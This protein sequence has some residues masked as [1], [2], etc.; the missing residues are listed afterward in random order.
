MTFEK[1]QGAYELGRTMTLAAIS[2]RQLGKTFPV[3]AGF[4]MFGRNRAAKPA[5]QC[6]DLDVAIG[7][8][9][10]LLGP[11]G[12][13]KTTL[14]EILATLLLPSEGEARI[15]GH[16]V[17]KNADN[18]RGMVGYCPSATESFYP[19]LTA[20]ENLEF[21]ALINDLAS[22]EAK[23]RIGALIPLVGL[24]DSAAA[25][26]QKLSQGMKQRLAIARALLT[27]PPVLLL[28]EPSKSLDPLLQ[29][30][31]WRL[32]RGVIAEKMGKTILLVT[33]SLAEVN[34]ICDRMAILKQGRIV[35]EGP[36]A[37]VKAS[38]GGDDLGAAFERALL[39]ATSD[40][41]GAP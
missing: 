28:D 35:C 37:E 23:A 1:I 30:E 21:F 19:R 15:C 41:R 29:K 36:V 25:A 33:H 26:F 11:N 6:V 40:E 39:D 24:D 27:D 38:L 9:F 8:I 34:A 12:A 17:V 7:E 4:R 14:L 13:G 3:G 16:D 32:L 10:G 31:I 20:F 18:V 22:A 5:L 2:T